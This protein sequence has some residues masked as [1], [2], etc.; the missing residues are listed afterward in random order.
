M[1]IHYKDLGSC[2][3]IF[4]DVA[5]YRMRKDHIVYNYETNGRTKH[6]MFYQVKNNRS[7]DLGE[8][9]ICTLQPG[10]LL[11]LPHG[12]K[13]RSSVENR[14]YASDGIGISFYLST[15]EGEMIDFC[16]EIKLVHDPFSQYYKRFEKI[17]FSVMN[18]AENILRLKSELFSLFHEIFTVPE[19]RENFQENY[20]DIIPAIRILENNPEKNLSVKDL[21]SLCLM[22]ESSF[23]RKFKQF[24]GGISPIRYRNHIRL[25]LAEELAHSPLTLNQ[26]A[27]QLGFYDGAHLC[28]TYKQEKGITL[29]GKIS[30]NP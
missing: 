19:R 10:N 29:K 14:D 2:D 24:S 11:F 23:L 5:A 22:S 17:L 8:T 13:Y 9:H 25:M 30:I 1:I 6:L 21:A 15:P 18:P 20:E 3:F 26:I 28:K 27:E 16:E 12:V 4:R 7:Y